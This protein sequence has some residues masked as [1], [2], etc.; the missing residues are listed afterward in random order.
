MILLLPFSKMIEISCANDCFQVTRETPRLTTREL[1]NFINV[2]MKLAGRVL[3]EVVI[4]SRG[5]CQVIADG[6]QVYCHGFKR[7]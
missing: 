7:T 3:H 6:S 1:N 5:G 2:D 4:G